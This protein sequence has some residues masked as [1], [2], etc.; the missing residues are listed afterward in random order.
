MSS[1]PGV[2]FGGAFLFAS[3]VGASCYGIGYANII[4]RMSRHSNAVELKRMELS[5]DAI[6]AEAWDKLSM[7]A[8][9]KSSSK[10]GYRYEASKRELDKLVRDFCDLREEMHQGEEMGHEVSFRIREKNREALLQNIEK[11]RDVL[12]RSIEKIHEHPLFETEGREEYNAMWFMLKSKTRAVTCREL[13]NKFPL[14]DF[15]SAF[16]QCRLHV[17]G[18][19]KIDEA[20]D[21]FEHKMRW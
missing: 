10:D 6:R 3:L 16:R 21:Q 1:G 7:R 20:M 14:R 13:M 17:D 19:V 8:V 9:L 2:L 5:A 4:D 18:P 12:L 11:N 15:P